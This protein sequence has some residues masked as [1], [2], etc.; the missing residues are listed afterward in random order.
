MLIEQD[1]YQQF[2][3]GTKGAYAITSP[4]GTG[5]TGGVYEA[6]TGWGIYPFMVANGAKHATSTA[7]TLAADLKTL[8]MTTNYKNVNAPRFLFA[9]EKVIDCLNTVLKDPVHYTPADKTFDMGLDVYNI[10]PTIKIV[11]I[12]CPLHEVRSNLFS[13]A[14][15]N[16]YFVLD[17]DVV[18]PVCE[19]GQEPFMHGNTSSQYLHNGGYNDYIDYWVKANISMQMDTVDGCF[20]GDVIGI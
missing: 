5:L 12:T 3:N 17:V 6:K 15:E 18:Q 10:S 14:F 1:A 4:A 9:T 2:W 7:A 13:A 11:P 16:R 20:Y 19:D 8:C